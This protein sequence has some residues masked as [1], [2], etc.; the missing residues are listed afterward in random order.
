M[1]EIKKEDCYAHDIGLLIKTDDWEQLQQQILQDQKLR[2]VI[3]KNI[4]NLPTQIKNSP[5]L[6]WRADYELLLVE[7]QTLLEESKK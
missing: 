3:E 2:G 1:L 4:K 5:T 7:F 6:V